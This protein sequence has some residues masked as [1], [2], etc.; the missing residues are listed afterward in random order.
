[1]ILLIDALPAAY[2]DQRRWDLAEPSFHEARELD[3]L[4]PKREAASLRSTAGFRA[5]APVD[6]PEHV[7]QAHPG[8][9]GG[10]PMGG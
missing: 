10:P 2:V 6:L 4:D 9:A 3:F 7:R 8:R 5:F 1:V